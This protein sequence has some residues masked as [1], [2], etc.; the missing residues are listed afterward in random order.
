MLVLKKKNQIHFNKN[1]GGGSSS[2]RI[3]LPNP[4]ECRVKV[5]MFKPAAGFGMPLPFRAFAVKQCLY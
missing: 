5:T 4:D 1:F 3:V 2:D